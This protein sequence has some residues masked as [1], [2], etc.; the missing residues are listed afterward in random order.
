MSLAEV[1]ALIAILLTVGGAV[2]YIIY[3]KRRGKGCVGCPYSKSCSGHCSCG[4]KDAH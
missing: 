2:G 1:L 4:E 3:S